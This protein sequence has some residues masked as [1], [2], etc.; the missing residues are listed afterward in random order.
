MPRYVIKFKEFSI[1]S[2]CLPLRLVLSF[3]SVQPA[4]QPVSAGVRACSA[5]AEFNS[6]ANSFNLLEFIELLIRPC[7]LLIFE[8]GFIADLIV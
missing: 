5:M 1:W 7:L 2:R 8:S 3:S 6:I 4:S